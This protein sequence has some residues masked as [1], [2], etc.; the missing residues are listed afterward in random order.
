MLV[1]H[2]SGISLMNLGIFLRMCNLCTGQLY[3]VKGIYA[4]KS[5]AV[6]QAL[7]FLGLF[8]GLSSVSGV[9]TLNG[10]GLNKLLVFVLV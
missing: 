7:N 3:L 6:P 8:L 9:L 5:N 1:K 4:K 10:K 2:S